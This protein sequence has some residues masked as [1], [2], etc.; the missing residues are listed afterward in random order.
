VWASR[1]G[2]WTNGSDNLPYDELIGDV[3][4]AVQEALVQDYDGLLRIAPAWPLAS[5]DVSGTE[6]I[7]GN[8]RVH[9]QIEG[10]R[11]VTV[12]LEAGSTGDVTMRNPWGSQ[13]VEIVDGRS[14]ATVV[15]ATPGPLLTI[16]A[17]TGGS[18][19]V[20]PMSSPNALL[21][22]A[23]VTASAAIAPRR[24]GSVTIGVK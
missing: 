4:N 2:N 12:V 22:H 9:V 7:H 1:L 17:Q 11:L 16:P 13:V 19:V 23:P 3:A 24:M 18:Y 20:E 6:Y 21:A 5:W 14:G 15:A 8:D 10:G